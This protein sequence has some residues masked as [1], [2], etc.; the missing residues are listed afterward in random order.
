MCEPK[1][2]QQVLIYLFREERTDNRALTMDVTGRN[3]PPVT[4]PTGWL[5]VEMI[6]THRLSP[7]WDT[8]YL[9]YAVRQVRMIG[10]YLFEAGRVPLIQLDCRTRR[11]QSL[12]A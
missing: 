11:D 7:R 5:F 10:F 12:K 2:G 6:D 3:I 9:R 8:A 4:S 1:R